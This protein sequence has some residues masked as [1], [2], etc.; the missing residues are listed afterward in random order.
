[1]SDFELRAQFYPLVSDLERLKEEAAE[2]VPYPFLAEE[3]LEIGRA[4]CRERV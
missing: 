2:G 1:M 3:V 4:S